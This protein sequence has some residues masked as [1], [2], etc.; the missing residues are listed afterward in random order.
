IQAFLSKPGGSVIVRPEMNM[1]IITDYAG[2][3][4]RVAG[5]IEI[6]DRPGDET[7]TQF[8]P[9][10]YVATAQLSAQVSEL[11]KQQQSLTSPEAQASRPQTIVTHEERTNQI[12]VIS[13]GPPDPEAL[14]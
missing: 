5:L 12:I 3:L 8:I 9:V 11:L 4:R 14:R 2:V 10:Q 13:A 7:T 6:I 1:L